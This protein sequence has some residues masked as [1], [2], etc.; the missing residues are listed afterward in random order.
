[1]VSYNC[2][3]FL[4]EAIASVYEYIH[5]DKEVIVVDNASSDNTVNELEIKFP[6]VKF[7][8]NNFNAG[9][10]AANN[11]GFKASKGD[12]LLFFNPDA[13]LINS[14]INKALMLIEENKN[15]IIGPKILNP[16]G[17]LQESVIDIPGPLTILKEA[18]FL[19]YFFAHDRNSVFNKNKYA[20]SG[21]CLLMPRALY[22]KLHGFDE[23]LFWMDDV[24]LCYRARQNGVDVRYFSG[25]SVKHTIGVSSKKNYN[26]VIANQLI[27]KLKFF[28]KNKRMADYFISSF[29]VE[30]H[31]LL[32]IVLFLILSFFKTEFRKKLSAYLYTQSAFCRYIF[33]K[34]NKVF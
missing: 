10:S 9:F 8:A 34:E 14:D 24:D 25:W 12:V 31:I 5:F 15:L 26:T 28:K 3:D 33:L 19:N 4:A 18:L 17:S 23:N 13:K 7:I 6:E 30:L 21:A 27:S 29:F 1:M 11:Q 22:A 20:L 32:R 16:D 2:K